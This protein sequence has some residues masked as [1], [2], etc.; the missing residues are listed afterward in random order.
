MCIPLGL[1]A[2]APPAPTLDYQVTGV[3]E[4][5][6]K[7]VLAWLQ[8]EQKNAP[9]PL[10]D[11]QINTLYQ[12]GFDDVAKSTQPYGYFQTQVTGRLTQTT[13]DHYLATYHVTL[14]KPMPVTAINTNIV[15]QGQQNPVLI[16]ALHTCPLK[17]G[18]KL[19]IVTYQQCKNKLQ[20][21]ALQQGY[22]NAHF[23]TN[24]VSIHL[25]QYQATIDLVFDTGQQYYFG[26]VFFSK[27]PMSD[28]LLQR[29]VSASHI[30]E[31]NKYSPDQLQVLQQNLNNSRYFSNVSIEPQ[32]NNPN[33]T[34]VPIQVNLVPAPKQQYNFGVGYGT[35]T[36]IRGT[37]GVNWNRL[38]SS[39]Q[40]FHTL[41]QA[42]QVQ[43]SLDAKYS[44]P[45][46]NPVTQQYFISGN[47]TNQ[48][49][50]TSKGHTQKISVGKTFL[51]D[52]WNSTFALSQQ[53]DQ[54]ELRGGPWLQSHLTMPNINLLRSNNDNPVFPRHGYSLSL[55][56]RGATKATGSSTNFTQTE[57]YAKWI[58]SPTALS[59]LL[60]RG[61]I[62]LTAVKN[63][64]TIPLSLQFFAGGAE[65][66]RGYN[67]EQL[68]PGRYLTVGSIEFQ[69]QVR[70]NWY[71]AVF[72]DAGNAFNSFTNPSQQGQ[73]VG[74]KNQGVN[75]HQLLKFGTGV[76]IVWV[77]PVGPMEITLAKAL[78]DKKQHPMIQFTMGTNL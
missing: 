41:L 40:S 14:G 50:N 70:P 51:W 5:I 42:S 59:R 11:A 57:L 9:T 12:N 63:P 25:K 8:A 61:D 54:Y 23:S 44:F 76:G 28:N 4:I 20:T 26:K 65:S 55:M 35:D 32:T 39:G 48:T 52:R 47:I 74:N 29:Y 17:V 67:Y 72:F 36:G 49:P 21:V 73:A 13:Q 24:Q 2:M 31:G 58:T 45:G 18:R 53:F 3:N 68:G 10:T 75:L 69:H 56:A 6:Q 16:H 37:V 77:S 33:Q 27:N 71:G 46:K 1:Y 30:D 62:G 64:D 78:T 38:T 60:F 7:N 34:T 15:G 22:L 19:N 43:T 66:V